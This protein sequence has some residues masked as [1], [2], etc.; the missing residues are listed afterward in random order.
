MAIKNR[1]K[2]TE[3][4]E[5]RSLFVRLRA[6]PAEKAKIDM[7]ASALDMANSEYMRQVLLSDADRV[8]A[9]EQQTVLSE[10]AWDAFSRELEAPAKPIPALAQFLKRKPIWDQ[11]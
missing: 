1:K 3:A 4:K 2:K 6:T 5:T 8:L 7:A 11:T 9:R 10:Q